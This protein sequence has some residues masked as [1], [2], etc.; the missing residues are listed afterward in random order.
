MKKQNIYLFQLTENQRKNFVE[1]LSNHNFIDGVSDSKTCLFW[2][3]N[4]NR[5]I[6]DHK[7]PL[8]PKKLLLKSAFGYE[9]ILEDNQMKVYCK[10]DKKCLNPYHIRMDNEERLNKYY[11][12]NEDCQFIT[13]EMYMNYK[14]ECLEET[15]KI[16]KDIV[17]VNEKEKPEIILLEVEKKNLKRKHDEPFFE[18]VIIFDSKKKKI[19]ETQT[20][21]EE[22]LQFENPKRQP[23][24]L[25]DLIRE[26][27]N[28]DDLI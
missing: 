3:G 12:I 2:T 27:E 25:Q 15:A 17:V 28:E 10:K 22:Q 26:N 1:K 4:T 11:R 13:N 5:I 18:N 7:V 24:F 8:D 9:N 21:K 19:K 23:L 6:I 14:K 20:Q 16:D